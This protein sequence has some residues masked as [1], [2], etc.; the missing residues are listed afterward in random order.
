MYV[1]PKCGG[2]MKSSP[3]KAHRCLR[4]YRK[5]MAERNRQTANQERMKM[6]NPMENPAIREKM[7]ETLKRIGHKPNIHGGN[8][9]GAT[10]PQKLLSDAL[11][12]PTEVVVAT[13]MRNLWYPTC[14]KIDIANRE[15]KIAIEVDGYS[16]GA[17]RVKAADAKKTKFLESRGWKV[18]RFTNDQVLNDLEKCVAMVTSIT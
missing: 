11:G 9:T 16:H 5:E 3:T 12:W 4:C 13:K 17:L 10:I 15:Q 7:R 14:Y 1:C 2:P 8:G 18:L 6:H